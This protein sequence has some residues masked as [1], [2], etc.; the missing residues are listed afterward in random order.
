MKQKQRSWGHKM[1]SILDTTSNLAH[2]VT[3]SCCPHPLVLYIFA[4]HPHID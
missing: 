4:I 2:S 3:L 1:S